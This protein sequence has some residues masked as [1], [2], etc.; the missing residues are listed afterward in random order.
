MVSGNH[1]LKDGSYRNASA[2]AQSI[3]IGFGSWIAAHGVIVSGVSLGQAS[4]VAAGAVVTRDVEPFS[5][6]AGVPARKIRESRK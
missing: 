1:A 2:P 3:K 5:V 4:L 6:V